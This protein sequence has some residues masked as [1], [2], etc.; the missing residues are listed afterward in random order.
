ME[1]KE[2]TRDEM[3]RHNYSNELEDSQVEKSYHYFKGREPVKT[4]SKS[5]H[6]KGKWTIKCGVDWEDNA[7]YNIND[8]KQ[9]YY[10]AEANAAHIVKC[11]NAHDELVKA[12]ELVLTTADLPKETH[13][14]VQRAIMND[15]YGL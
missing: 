14:T 8:G 7:Y 4:E 2:V 15:K 6:T 12:L 1:S 11:V 13:D 5:L 9:G 10:E 3:P